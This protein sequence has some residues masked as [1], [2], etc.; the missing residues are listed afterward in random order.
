M[1][2][3]KKLVA[4]QLG[5]WEVENETLMVTALEV[6]HQ[7]LNKDQKLH[8]TLQAQ[9]IEA[10]VH[11][12]ALSS[13][14]KELL[15][16]NAAIVK[17]LDFLAVNTLPPLAQEIKFLRFKV[18][19]FACNVCGWQALRHNYVKTRQIVENAFKVPIEDFLMTLRRSLWHLVALPKFV[20][21]KKFH[22]GVSFSM[23]SWGL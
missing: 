18:F 16:G 12:R 9:M 2:E 11:E 3:S 6:E 10:E 5:K 13:C 4:K 8:L 1:V 15:V 17:I 14:A 20:F 19:Q 22:I 21:L 7:F 23:N